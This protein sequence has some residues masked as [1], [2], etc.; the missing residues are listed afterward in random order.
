MVRHAFVILLSNYLMLVCHR[1]EYN[2]GVNLRSRILTTVPD[3][4]SQKFMV[5][6]QVARR[7]QNSSNDRYA[8]V[9]LDFANTRPRQ[10]VD[11]DFEEWH[12]RTREHECLMGHKVTIIPRS[13]TKI[14][15]TDSAS[16]SNGISDANW[17]RTVMS[18]TSLLTRSST[19]KTAH[20]QLRTTNGASWCL[21]NVLIPLTCTHA[22][23][24]SD[25]NFVKQ[26][27]LCVAA[28]PEPI[29]A[30]VCKA[31]DT[32]QTYMGSSGYRR[33]PGNTCDRSQGVKKDERVEKSCSQGRFT[34]SRRMSV[35]L[36][37]DLRS[38]TRRG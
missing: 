18:A 37:L 13:E 30:G 23:A 34:R 12:A 7:D 35:K 31:E 1:K 27:D 36:I 11:S 2:I 3:S 8:V 16:V 20:V 22:N 14:L 5:I 4:T 28:G 25:Y 38:S 6:G 9:F 33:I 19:R 32:K 17:K 15:D 26:G 24:C 29:P 21:P 10:C